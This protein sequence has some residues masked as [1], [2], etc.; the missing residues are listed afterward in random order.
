MNLGENIYKLRT[1]KN[2]SQGDLADAL[3]VSRQSVSK[4]ENNSAVP[5]VEKLIRLAQIFNVSIDELITGQAAEHF[6]RKATPAPTKTLIGISLLCCCIVSA[7]LFL[8]FSLYIWIGLITIPLGIISAVCLAPNERFL[9]LTLFCIGIVLFAVI[10]FF[11][12]LLIF[13][14]YGILIHV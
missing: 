5:E 4:W 11:A 13:N 2:M 10:L 12:L 7:T 14:L 6:S 9:R 3:E 8:I 1:E